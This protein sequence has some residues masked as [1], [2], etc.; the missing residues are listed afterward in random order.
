MPPSPRAGS[1]GADRRQRR[2]PHVAAAVRRMQER[3]A[4]RARSKGL[5]VRGVMGYEGHVVGLA[6]RTERTRRLE[7][8]MEL[9]LLAHRLAGGRSSRPEGRGPTTPT[10]GRRRS[11][12]GSYPLMDTAYGKLGLP[13]AQALSVLATV[14]SVS[15]GWAVA[16]CGL[17]AFG[18]GPREIRPSKGPPSCSAPTSM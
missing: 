16:D 9:L 11:R 10:G 2:A 17:K 15:P 12:P 5:V 6:D 3:L 7:T 14:V 13:T 8:S 18:Y 4:D 1:R